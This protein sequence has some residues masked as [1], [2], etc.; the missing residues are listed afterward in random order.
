MKKLFKYLSVTAAVAVALTACQQI[1]PIVG[2]NDADG[3]FLNKAATTIVKG[4]TET[5]VATVTPKHDANIQWTSSDTNVAS[6]DN[7]GVVTAVGAGD[8]EIS[9]KYGN[10]VVV[11]SVHVASP[12]TSI[13]LDKHQLTIEKG[14][15]GDFSVTVG[16]DDINIP[17]KVEWISSDESIFSVT[18]DP[19][20]SKKAS[21]KGKKGGYASL[22]VRAGDVDDACDITINVDLTGLTILGYDGH[23]LFNGDQLQ[24]SV[25]KDPV[26]AIAE[27]DPVWS[28][29]DQSVATVDATG[30]V[31]CLKNGDVT[32]KVES[33]GFEQTLDLHINLVKDVTFDLT[34][35][36]A[37]R[38]QDGVTLT[39]DGGSYYSSYYGWYLRS[40]ASLKLS[41]ES[42]II[43]TKIVLTNSYGNGRWS[44]PTGEFTL[45]GYN[46]TWEGSAEGELTVSSTGSNYTTKMVVT[47][48]G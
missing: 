29:S 3:L 40:G 19:A 1:E 35:N 5:L 26:D 41:A 8:A 38:T 15:T 36:Q 34:T 2:T 43:I 11:C 9:A 12:V 25:E 23:K 47:I 10:G 6:V 16:P 21:I 39:I 48:K 13:T 44:A 4:S 17:Y 45:G 28:S 32:I 14:S 37:V 31:N 24:L 42:G 22:I 20:D 33:N 27:L 46:A 18:P 7:Q 30:L